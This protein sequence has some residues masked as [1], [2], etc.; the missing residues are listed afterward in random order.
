MFV[1]G[2]ILSHK[3]ERLKVDKQ[4]SR[5]EVLG[6]VESLERSNND[7]ITKINFLIEGFYEGDPRKKKKLIED[8]ILQ[9]KQE[10]EIDIDQVDSLFDYLK[11]LT[12]HLKRLQCT[13]TNL[14]SDERS[15][16]F[17]RMRKNLLKLSD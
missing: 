4:I 15:R 7:L 1:K 11:A 3:K 9:R 13:V 8:F 2:L 14:S 5:E 16:A 12:N 10:G 6:A 17:R